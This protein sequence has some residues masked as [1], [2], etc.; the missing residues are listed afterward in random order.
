MTHIAKADLTLR[1]RARRRWCLHRRQ[2]RPG[3]IKEVQRCDGDI[4]R[5][6][7][8]KDRARFR[9]VQRREPLDA[10]VST[11]THNGGQRRA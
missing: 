6:A 5:T 8:G 1:R 4:A 10:E 7:G 3:S 9:T 2:Q 11:T